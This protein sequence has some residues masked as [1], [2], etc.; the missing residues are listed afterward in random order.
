MDNR[1]R[2]WQ[3][4]RHH[5]TDRVPWHI[6]CTAPTRLKLEQYYGTQDLDTCLDQHIVK[7]RSR[8]PYEQIRPNYV[9]DEFGLIWDRTVDS[10]IGVVVEHPLKE[11]TLKGFTFP[12]PHDPRRFTNLPGFVASHP[13]R[14]RLYSVGFSLFER[15]WTLRGMENLMM[16]MLSEPQFVDE[17]LD[18]ILTYHL[19]LLSEALTYDI[20]GVQF[21]DD[22]G[23]QNGLLFG[24]R[25]WRRFI[26]PRIAE[27]YRAVHAAGKAVVIHS[28][29]K[30]QELFPE[31]IDLGVDVYNPFQ[32]DVMDPYA[33][34]R[35]FGDRLCFYGGISVQNLLPHGTPAQIQEEVKRLID[36]VGKGGGLIVGP[37]HDM[38][39]DIPLENLIALIDAIRSQA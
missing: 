10:D 9:R 3:S 11:A 7:Y 4:I 31:L 22:W 39:G 36:E 15:A 19:D 37:S 6:G 33:I 16:D 26:K 5:E 1:E 17:L 30:I 29:G 23:Q 18:A 34:K 32:P 38:P 20:D 2:V 27:L 25:L 14:F 12:D 21:G 24:P 13:D 28:C 35:Q 8:I